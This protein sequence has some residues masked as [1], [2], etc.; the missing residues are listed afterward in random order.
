M[1]VAWYGVWCL[2][3]IIFFV[4]GFTHPLTNSLFSSLISSRIPIDLR[5]SLNNFFACASVA[6]DGTPFL[7]ESKSPSVAAALILEADMPET[8]V[9]S[10]SL[11]PALTTSKVSRF[12]DL[13]GSGWLTYG[14]TVLSNSSVLSPPTTTVIFLYPLSASNASASKMVRTAGLYIIL[15]FLKKVFM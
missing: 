5:R 11:L 7:K 12:S 2:Q 6:E 4:R 9:A 10:G 15:A 1:C 13:L 14:R 3:A 8:S